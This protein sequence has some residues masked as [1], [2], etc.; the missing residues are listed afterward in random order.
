MLPAPQLVKLAIYTT[1]YTHT[2]QPLQL[3]A[4]M[5]TLQYAIDKHGEDKCRWQTMWCGLRTW[6][7][8]ESLTSLSF[9][10]SDKDP[11][12]AVYRCLL[13]GLTALPLWRPVTWKQ[14]C[15]ILNHRKVKKADH[16]NL[17]PLKM[18]AASL[19]VNC[20]RIHD[21]VLNRRDN[22]S[23]YFRHLV[24][25]SYFIISKNGSCLYVRREILF[26]A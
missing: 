18:G 24:S 5:W 17:M 25:V 23:H 7:R 13:T 1:I 16:S 2:F 14:L 6:C 15:V 9:Q 19:N 22:S 8:W 11:Q 26:L 21:N 3:Y 4:L 12:K 10:I 20:W